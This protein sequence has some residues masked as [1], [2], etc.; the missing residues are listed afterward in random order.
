[1]RVARVLV[2]A[3]TVIGCAAE[4]DGGGAPEPDNEGARCGFFAEVCDDG[5]YC[6]R[7]ENCGVMDEQGICRRIPI[8]CTPVDEPVCGCDG[9]EYANACE[10]ARNG[11]DDAASGS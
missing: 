6:D 10:A 8:E 2:F 9:E 7:E 5:L 4:D 11:V 1:M 3:I